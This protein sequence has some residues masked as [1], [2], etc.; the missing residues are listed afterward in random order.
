L[1]ADDDLTVD[2]VVVVAAGA[3]AGAGA[4]A[5][6]GDPADFRLRLA[7]FAET[8]GFVLS[9]SRTALLDRFRDAAFC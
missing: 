1:V 3:G 4:E 7:F 5:G 6:A 2:A 8:N 9:I